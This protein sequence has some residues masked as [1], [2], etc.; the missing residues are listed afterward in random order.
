MVHQVSAMVGCPIAIG[1][2]V[3]LASANGKGKDWA[4]MLSG[5][6]FGVSTLTVLGL[7]AQHAATI[8]PAD[9]IAAA[10]VWAIGLASVVLIFTPAAGRYYRPELARG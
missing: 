5:A 8:A 1:L 9:V 4:R 7:L 6:C 2:W 3:W 10:V